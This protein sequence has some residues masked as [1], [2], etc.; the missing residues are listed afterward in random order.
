M[1]ASV[2]WLTLAYVAVAA[3]LLNL[4]LKTRYGKAFK[5]AA[6]GVVSLLYFGA[7]HGSRGLMGWPSLDSMPERFRVLWIAMEEPDKASGAPGSIY[8]W[9]RALDAAGI[10]VGAPRAHAIPWS[11]EEAESAQAALDRMQEG[12]RLDGRRSRRP[13]ASPEEAPPVDDEA[14]GTRGSTSPGDRR[15]VFEFMPVAPPALPAKE[16][17]PSPRASAS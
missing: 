2:L 8:Y 3:L 7:W 5:A 17:P 4:N 16:D 10:A 6:I 12:E 14:W 9:V 13:L 11:E 1:T 15:P